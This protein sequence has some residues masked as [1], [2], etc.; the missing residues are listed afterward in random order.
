MDTSR[1]RTKRVIIPAALAACALAAGGVLWASAASANLHGNEAERVGNAAVRAVGGGVVTDAENS[2]DLGEAYEVEVRK[3]DGTEVDVSLDKDLKVVGRELDD[4]DDDSDGPDLDDRVLSGTERSSAEKA[5]LAAA[6]GGIA[7]EVK[8]SDDLGEAYEVEVHKADGTEVDVTL[9]KSFKVVARDVDGR[10]DD[11]DADDR[12]LSS[13]ERS[14]AAR[15]AQAAVGG[16]VAT[17]VKASDNLGEAYEVEVHKADGTEW[18]VHLDA[19]FKVLHKS[20]DD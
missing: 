15:A 20:F 3:P 2:D 10:D 19:G 11:R 13:S 18:D 14:S 7:T 17:D 12:I 9:D 6:G 4:R 8:A 5:A 16:G 1:L